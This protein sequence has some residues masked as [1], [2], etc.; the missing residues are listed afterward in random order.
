M[1]IR[2]VNQQGNIPE[3]MQ[4]MPEYI[5][6]YGTIMHLGTLIRFYGWL[7]LDNIGIEEPYDDRGAHEI[8]NNT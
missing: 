2:C 7:C 4:I 5:I 8:V 1:P 3:Q 6:L